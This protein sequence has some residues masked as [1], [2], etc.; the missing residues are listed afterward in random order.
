MSLQNHIYSVLTPLSQR[1]LELKSPQIWGPDGEVWAELIKRDVTDWEK[2]PYETPDPK[3]WHMLYQKLMDDVE[4][5]VKRGADE[6]KARL[7]DLKSAREHSK[8]VKAAEVPPLPK[9][10]GMK[11]VR[12]PRPVKK[13]ASTP[14][15]AL[16][17]TGQL[18]TKGL[19]GGAMFKRIKRE[20]REKSHFG[21]GS[22]LA[23]PTHKLS[24][25]ASKV[26]VPPPSIIYDRLH[27]RFEFPAPPTPIRARIELKPCALT[28]KKH[29]RDDRA[30]AA[31]TTA[32]TGL[33]A[34]KINVND[35]TSTVINPQSPTT[36]LMKE[37]RPGTS[38]RR[39]KMASPLRRPSNTLARPKPVDPFMPAKRRRL[40]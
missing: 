31:T 29:T 16:A 32:A 13:K 17:F 6:L 21:N 3:N 19:S 28:S 34:P 39:P 33:L 15:P 18:K 2:R 24:E 35:D 23:V 8:Q 20:V 11:L 9:M 36:S 10:G 5:E 27:P 26:L 40:S 12:N 30:S 25:R 38:G 4:A 22:K 14:L 1:A 37:S 7:Q